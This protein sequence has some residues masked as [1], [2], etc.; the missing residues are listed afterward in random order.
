MNSLLR[1]CNTLDLCGVIHVPVLFKQIQRFENTFIFIDFRK[2]EPILL[3]DSED[4][5]FKSGK[6][7]LFILKMCGDELKTLSFS[8][9]KFRVCISDML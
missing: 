2:V 9:K 8:V 6:K 3:D 1:N 4:D 7:M 5:I